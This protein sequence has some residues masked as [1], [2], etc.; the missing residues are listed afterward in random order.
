MKIER[1]ENGREDKAVSNTYRSM[2]KKERSKRNSQVDKIN[3]LA[4]DKLLF[5]H[6]TD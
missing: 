2:G 3:K 6:A 5:P 1:V 4:H